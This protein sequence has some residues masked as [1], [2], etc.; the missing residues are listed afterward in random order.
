MNR[1]QGA[2]GSSL[3]WIRLINSLKNLYKR[4]EEDYPYVFE[5]KTYGMEDEKRAVIAQLLHDVREFWFDRHYMSRIIH[6]R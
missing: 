1:K 6:L 3:N 2:M 4:L 5:Y